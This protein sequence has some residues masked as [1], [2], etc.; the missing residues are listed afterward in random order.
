MTEYKGVRK[1]NML[2]PMNK[3]HHGFVRRALVPALQRNSFEVNDKHAFHYT[4]FETGARQY[5]SK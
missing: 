3:Y 4:R 2:W 5:D 1:Q